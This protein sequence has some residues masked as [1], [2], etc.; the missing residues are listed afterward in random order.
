MTLYVLPRHVQQGVARAMVV[1]VVLAAGI[2]SLN[3][4][5]EFAGFRVAT[6]AVDMA[7]LGTGGSN[8][9][10]LL[11]LDTQHYGLLVAQIYFGLWLVP[12]GYPAYR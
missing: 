5:F 9:V 12:L 3:A 1:L 7:A 11:L 10:V 8:V 4:V 2:S 6:S